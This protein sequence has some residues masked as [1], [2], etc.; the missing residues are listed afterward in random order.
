LINFAI[1]RIKYRKDWSSVEV[2]I[3]TAMSLQNIQ[4]HEYIVSEKIFQK[5]E[6]EWTEFI[7]LYSKWLNYLK[8]YGIDNEV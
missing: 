1:L 2:H 3:K 8:T 4:Q 6:V 5:S 7:G